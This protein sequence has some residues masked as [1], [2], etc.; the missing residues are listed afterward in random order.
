MFICSECDKEFTKKS[1]LNRH[2]LNTHQLSAQQNDKNPT[3]KCHLCDNSSYT[4]VDLIDHL[5]EAHQQQ[6]FLEKLSFDNEMGKKLVTFFFYN[7]SFT[8]I[9]FFLNLEFLC[10]KSKIEIETVTDWVVQSKKK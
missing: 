10:W 5:F 6:V 1:S 9:K 8:Y 3:I 2:L 4:K 7:L